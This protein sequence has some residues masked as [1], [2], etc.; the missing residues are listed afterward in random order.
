MRIKTIALYKFSELSEESKKRAIERYRESNDEIFWQDEIFDSMIKVF[1][2]CDGVSLK[3]YSLGLCSYSYVKSEFRDDATAELTGARALGWLE[4]NLFS[5]L[6]MTRS[7]YLKN[8][9]A[10]FG[11]GYR[12]GKIPDCPL[13][14]YCADHDF[15]EALTENVL[16]GKTLKDS[17]NSL[18]DT[19]VKLLES[20]NDSQN[21]EEY[22]SEH[23]EANEY[24]FTED[25]KMA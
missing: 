19:Y 11:Y 1:E 23:F 17:F 8:R 12:V 20:E 18:A 24:E 13:T 21:S 3:D 25:G 10:N 22:I 9:K 5:N 4:N 6:R 7:Q 2:K 16:S 14:G 15:L